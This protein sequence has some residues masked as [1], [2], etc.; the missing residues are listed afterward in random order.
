MSSGIYSRRVTYRVE[1]DRLVREW[2]L[3]DAKGGTQTRR[4]VVAQPVRG[5]YFS[6]RGSVIRIELEI[7]LPGA[8]PP[9]VVA[10]HVHLRN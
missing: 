6:R 10:T 5:V 4:T 2:D 3:T 1:N 9:K 7:D 8:D